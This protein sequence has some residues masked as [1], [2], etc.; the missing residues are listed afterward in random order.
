MTVILMFFCII[1]TTS[2]FPSGNKEKKEPAR[3]EWENSTETTLFGHLVQETS[4]NL[5]LKVLEKKTQIKNKKESKYHAYTITEDSKTKLKKAIGNYV[6]L[7]GNII[8]TSVDIRWLRVTKVLI[9]QKSSKPD[10]SNTSHKE[11]KGLVELGKDNH[12]CIVTEWQSRSRV[13]YYIYGEH[14]HTIKKSLGCIVKARGL[15]I[16]VPG[17]GIS[18]TEYIYI[19]KIDTIEENKEYN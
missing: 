12:V 8:E 17:R 1:L 18:F 19:E 11:I 9:I 10:W 6:F 16:D 2:A 15:M 5:I 7:K 14:I 3:E 4:N 13:S